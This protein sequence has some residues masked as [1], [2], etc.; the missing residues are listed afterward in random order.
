[1][2]QN[3]DCRRIISKI[4]DFLC[5][6]FGD[7][8]CQKRPLK[9]EEIVEDVWKMLQKFV[10]EYNGYKEQLEGYSLTLEAHLE[11]LSQTYEE[12]STMFSISKILSKNINPYELIE[13]FLKAILNSVPSESAEIILFTDGEEKILKIGSNLHWEKV[14]EFIREMFKN[15]RKDVIIS[16]PGDKIIEGI[17]NFILVPIIS[18]DKLWGYMGLFNKLNG[19]FYVAADRK[20]LESAAMQLGFSLRNYEYLKQEIERQKLQEQLNIAKDIQSRLLPKDFPRTENFEVYAKTVPAIFVGGDYYDIVKREDGK[21]LIVFADVSGKSVPAA[22]L[23]SSIRTIV[24]NFGVYSEPVLSFAKKINRM[25]T[26][27]TPEDQFTTMILMVFD[28][29]KLEVEVCNAGH[30]PMIVISKNDVKKVDATGIPF[31]IIEDF[32][33]EAVNIKLKSGDLIFIYTDGIS[34][35]RNDKGEEFGHDRIIAYLTEKNTNNAKIIVEKLI[36]QVMQ[37]STGVNQ[38]DDITAMAIKIF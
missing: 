13:D 24:R 22:L 25:I 35:A 16:E 18:G 9:E 6:K 2:S 30:N 23:M 32:E 12:L 3:D 29:Q 21:Y 11:E 4:Y 10:E 5:Q 31:G 14:L 27:D 34:E 8:D 37:F 7:T 20:I 19:D 17:K 1:M 26:N 33:Y 38:H 36:D 28:P 15:S